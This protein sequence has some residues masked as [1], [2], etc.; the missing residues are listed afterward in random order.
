MKNID[1]LKVCSLCNKL[2]AVKFHVTCSIDLH[3]L[4]FKMGI[5]MGIALRADVFS[6]IALLSIGEQTEL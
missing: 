4:S 1:V 6:T 2:T 3:I 5:T